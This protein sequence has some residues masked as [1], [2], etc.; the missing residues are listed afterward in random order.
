MDV[1]LW[2]Y[3]WGGWIGI[4]FLEILENGNDKND[5]YCDYYLPH[6]IG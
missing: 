5:D 4:G 6:D 2:C 3:G 1:A